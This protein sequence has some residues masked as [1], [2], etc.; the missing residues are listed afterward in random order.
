MS[1]VLKTARP[2]A[3]VVEDEFLVGL[4]IA[5]QLSRLTYEVVGPAGR[6]RDGIALA[7]NAHDLVLAVLDINLAGEK[8]WPVARALKKRDVPFIFVS[9]YS[10]SQAGFPSDLRGEILCPKPVEPEALR[11]AVER[12]RAR[13]S[14]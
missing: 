11:R 2:R 12:A 5:D 10:E 3:L 6:V 9:G 8:S 4:D 13:S 14:A 7:E 1:G